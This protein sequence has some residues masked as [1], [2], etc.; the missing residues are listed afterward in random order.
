MKDFDRPPEAVN[1]N[2]IGIVQK[3]RTEY[4]YVGTIRR[5]RGQTLFSF[6]IAKDSALRLLILWRKRLSILIV[7]KM[8]N[9]E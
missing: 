3:T 5:K 7:L 8:N 9:Y 1:R 6:M 4:K 2:E